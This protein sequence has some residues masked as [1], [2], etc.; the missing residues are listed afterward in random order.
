MRLA[1]QIGA[2][3]YLENPIAADDLVKSL[4]RIRRDCADNRAS[5]SSALYAV[6]SAKGGSGASFVAVNLAHIMA[7]STD[8]RVALLDLDL[9]FSSLAQYLDLK[10]DHGLLQALDMADQLDGVALDAY[11]AKHRSG[12]S[13]LGVMEDEMVLARDIPLERFVRLLDIVKENY[14]RVVVDL[15]RQIDDVTAAA[16]ERADR[17]VLVVQQELANLRDAARLRRILVRE[18]GLPEE[19]MVVVVNRY[20]KNLPVELQDIKRALACESQELMLVPNHYRNVAESIDVGVPMLDHARG[21]SVTKAL[22]QIE[23]RLMGPG[24]EGL[25]PRNVLSRAFS[26][27]IRG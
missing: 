1:M 17:V 11:M 9:Q 7:A 26:N 19:K 20:D 5:R 23:A 16:Y 27:L 3:D 24:D 10:P 18:L 14:D 22:M 25:A 13:L 8:L 4:Q 2:R 15:P 21:S 12:L 6:V